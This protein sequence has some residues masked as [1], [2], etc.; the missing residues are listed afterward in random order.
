MKFSVSFSVLNHLYS[1]RE[2]KGLKKV[3]LCKTEIWLF[4]YKYFNLNYFYAKT[5]SFYL[6]GINFLIYLMTVMEISKTCV[7][8]AYFFNC[9]VD[10]LINWTTVINLI[11]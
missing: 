10:S 4:Y 9:I 3:S 6:K 7:Y 2:I 5:D 1:L 8:L 11:F